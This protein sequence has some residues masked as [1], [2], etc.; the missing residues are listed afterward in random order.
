MNNNINNNTAKLI[1]TGFGVY[2]EGERKPETKIGALHLSI[3]EINDQIS[4]INT[5]I[6]KIDQLIFIPKLQKCVD[7][8][9]ESIQFKTVN[10]ELS[11]IHCRLIDSKESLSNILEGLE[12]QLDSNLRLV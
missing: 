7:D 6:S 10:G 11:S 1:D 8:S 12:T 2:C 3:I 4:M 5:I 9:E